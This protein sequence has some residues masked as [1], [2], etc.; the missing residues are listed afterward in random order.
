MPTRKT[1]RA[2][3][4]VRENEALKLRSLSLLS[5]AVV[6]SEGGDE[7]GVVHEFLFDAEFWVV[8]YI[9]VRVGDWLTGDK[10]LVPPAAVKEINWDLPKVFLSLRKSQLKKSH[11]PD[12]NLFSTREMIEYRIDALNGEVGHVGDF[13]ADEDDWTIYYLV[14]VLDEIIPEEESSRDVLISTEWVRKSAKE[15]ERV[16]ID[17]DRE[18]V[19]NSPEYDPSVPLDREYELALYDHYGRP[20]YW[21]QGGDTEEEEDTR[22]S[23]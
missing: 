16:Y 18:M 4:T 8:R 21:D 12:P 5:E 14:V 9:G 15:E 23:S 7:I 19:L 22:F 10:I 2:S 1:P 11:V 13:I 20:R 6:A 3:S 17:L